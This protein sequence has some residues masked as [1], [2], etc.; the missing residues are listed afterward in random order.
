MRIAAMAIA[1]VGAL[2]LGVGMA[3][4]ALA[5]TGPGTVTAVT[6]AADHPDTTN[7]SGSATINDPSRGPVW[8]FDNLSVRFTVTPGS[9]GADGG[10]YSVL[11]TDNGSFA[12][13]ANPRTGDALV[14][15]GSV[16]GTIQY[17]VSSASAPDPSLLLAQQPG[18]STHDQAGLAGATTTGHML[19]QLFGGNGNIVGGGHYRFTYR[20]VDGSVYVQTG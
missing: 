2:G 7:V 13:F 17:D 9:T 6:H 12:G 20:L 8:A 15:N 4:T 16:Q 14:S 1:G 3:R 5:G 19:S 18:D 10:N 11:I